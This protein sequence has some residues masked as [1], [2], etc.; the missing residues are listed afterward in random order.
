MTVWM[1]RA[2]TLRSTLRQD[3]LAF[4]SAAIRELFEET[5]LLLARTQCGEWVQQDPLEDYR[6]ALNEQR[7]SWV[8]VLERTDARLACNALHYFSYWVTPRE[9]KKRYSTRFF[10]AALPPRQRATHCG[11]ELTDSCWLTAADALAAHADKS[12]DLPPPTLATL[13]SVLELGSLQ[14]MLDWTEACRMTGVRRI[15]P[16]LLHVN[17]ERRVVMPGDADYPKEAP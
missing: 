13:K 8:E 7:Q 16:V 1:R 11:G 10:M 14:A 15:R 3:G 2:P 17:G 5:G 4:Y 9:R 6:E 12:I